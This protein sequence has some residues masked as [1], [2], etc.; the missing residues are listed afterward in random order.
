MLAFLDTLHRRENKLH[1]VTSGLG[2]KTN[3]SADSK[4]CLIWWQPIWLMLLYVLLTACGWARW[5]LRRQINTLTRDKQSTETVPTK[6]S[7][8]NSSRDCERRM[9]CVGECDWIHWNGELSLHFSVE[10]S[11]KCCYGSELMPRCGCWRSWLL[12][13]S[14]PRAY[15]QLGSSALSGAGFQGGSEQS[16]PLA[17]EHLMPMHAQEL[18]GLCQSPQE[19]GSYGGGP[20]P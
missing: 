18:G 7:C 16:K 13:D 3:V 17:G 15:A 12:P 14:P 5:S 9:V 1:K 2:T 19:A 10:R 20:F 6:M 11:W 8:V 4:G